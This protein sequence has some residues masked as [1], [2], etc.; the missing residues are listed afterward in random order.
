MHFTYIMKSLKDQGYYFGHCADLEVRLHRHNAGKVRSIK[1]RTPFILH[2]FE[3]FQTKSEAFAREKF[4][5][6]L[7]GRKWLK[8]NNII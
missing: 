8:E 5:K 7:E 4:F 6:S 2:Y 3:E 1:S